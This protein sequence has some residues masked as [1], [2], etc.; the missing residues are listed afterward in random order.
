MVKN[1]TYSGSKPL[2]GI[3]GVACVCVEGGLEK[4][5]VDGPVE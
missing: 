4:A 3:G 1:T 5:V 2:N